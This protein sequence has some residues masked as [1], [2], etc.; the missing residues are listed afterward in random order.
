MLGIGY[1]TVRVRRSV[2]S[3]QPSA[4]C[5]LP[6]ITFRHGGKTV[7]VEPG[8]LWTAQ[9]GENSYR[10][11]PAGELWEIV[12]EIRGGAPWR[13]IVARHYEKTSAA[14]P[15]LSP[16]QPA[17]FFSA[18]TRRPPTP[19]V[20]DLGSGWGQI[21]LPLAKNKNTKSPRSNPPRNDWPSSRRRP[22]KN[23]WLTACISCRRISSTSN[24]NHNPS[25]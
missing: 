13:A 7:T 10:D 15:E 11:T 20:L 9:P 17:I 19:R 5:S 12:R 8:G 3:V 25:I 14:P 23:K 1:S 24:L 22:R 4:F 21:A 16:A 18:N 6:M 2:F